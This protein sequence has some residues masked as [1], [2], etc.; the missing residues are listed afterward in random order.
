MR[1]MYI[2]MLSGLSHVLS[3]WAGAVRS[4]LGPAD[5]PSKTA[6]SSDTWKPLQTHLGRS[7]DGFG[8]RQ[9]KEL[10]LGVATASVGQIVLQ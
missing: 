5:L 3:V 2:L 9:S 6:K 7:I 10:T 4:C 1:D 8:R